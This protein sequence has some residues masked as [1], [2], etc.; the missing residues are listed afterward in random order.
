VAARAAREQHAAEVEGWLGMGAE[1]QRT[2][3]P[4]WRW[5]E[6]CRLLAATAQTSSVV[7]ITN[8][9]PSTS[10]AIAEASMGALRA[11]DTPGNIQRHRS[12]VILRL[13]AATHLR[14]RV[15]EGNAAASLPPIPTWTVD[16]SLLECHSKRPRFTNAAEVS[17]LRAWISRVAMRRTSSYRKL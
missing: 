10:S 4:L 11:G 6:A 3:S 13:F 8:A 5:N 16:A 12:A 17:S 1:E 7:T 2:E 15:A 9:S 14:V